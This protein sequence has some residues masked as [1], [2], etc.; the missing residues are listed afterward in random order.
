MGEGEKGGGPRH[1][2]NGPMATLGL[3]F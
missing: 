2:S 1:Y 3:G